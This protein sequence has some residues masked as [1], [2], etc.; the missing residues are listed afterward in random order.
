M[1]VCVCA[2]ACVCARACVCVRGGH[3]VAH[4]YI[5]VHF[6]LLLGNGKQCLLHILLQFH[7]EEGEGRVRE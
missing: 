5:W 7:W 6:A 2:C 4:T 1:S 3:V